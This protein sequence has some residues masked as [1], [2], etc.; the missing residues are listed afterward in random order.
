M[1]A[2]ITP[3]GERGRNMRWPVTAAFYAVG[4]FLGGA[5][6]GG[7]AGLAGLGWRGL[8]GPNRT[9]TLVAVVVLSA[10]SVV[11]DSG[12][13][14][15]PIPT[16]HRQ[17]SEEWLGRYRGWVYG[18]TFGVQLGLGVVT[19][20]TTAAVYL[21]AALAFL[22]PSLPDA[23]LVGS[24]FGLARALPLLL[25]ARVNTPQQL[26]RLHRRLAASR[27]RVHGLTLATETLVGAAAVLALAAQP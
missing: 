4:S 7:L 5:L 3:L 25:A 20:V 8:S 12:L 17:V 24:T 13:T 2:S 26:G 14:R 11:A 19:T 16:I 27:E 1:L 18:L 21:V 9:V 23:V 15:R 22:S 10:A 6:L